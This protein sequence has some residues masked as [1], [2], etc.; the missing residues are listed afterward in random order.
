MSTPFARK[1]DLRWELLPLFL[2]ILA[3]CL[4]FVLHGQRLDALARS[5]TDRYSEDGWKEMGE[6]IRWGIPLASFGAYLVLS[7]MMALAARV[8]DP[9]ADVNFLRKLSGRAPLED[10][11]LREVIRGRL[12]RSAYLCKVVVAAV[13]IIAQW[14]YCGMLISHLERGGP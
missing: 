10:P 6:W 8:R 2:V 1:P 7:L 11:A 4:G 3:F 13:A 5:G 9:I 12:L 14:A